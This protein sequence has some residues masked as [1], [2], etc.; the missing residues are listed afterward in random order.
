MQ[1]PQRGELQVLQNVVIDVDKAGIITAVGHRDG[2][3]T[4]NLGEQVVLLPGLIDTHMHAPQW[5]QLGTGLDLPLEQWL[6]EHT[7]PLEK[8]LTE[9]EF[10]A[11]VWP[12]MVQGLLS[13]GTTTAVYYATISVETTTML[14]ATCA[15]FGQRAFVGR[16]AMDYPGGTP[17]WYRD[18]DASAAIADSHASIEA[19]VGLGDGAVQPIITP[20]FAPACSN[21]ALIGLGQLS[22]ETGVRLQTHCSESDWQHEYAFERFRTSDTNA[23]A[24]F[25]LI[26]PNTVLAHGNHLADSDL[27]VIRLAGAGVAHCPLSNA[28]FGNSVFPARQALDSGVKVGLGTDIAGGASPGLLP[29]CAHAVTA[30]RYLEDG[31]NAALPAGDRGVADSRISIRDAFYMATVGGADL[32]N[33]PAGL[34]AVGRSFDALAVQINRQGSPLQ[35]WSELDRGDQI[36]E[37]VIRL[38]SPA[39]IEDVW[40]R[41]RRVAGSRDQA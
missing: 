29:Q 10:A 21:D 22:M 8:R 12:Q 32:L 33:I 13:H 37:K 18:A 7:F 20:R 35:V 36:F 4:H 41:G 27:D 34:L 30:S 16:V 23:L 5:P 17:E 19:I 38:A 11:K 15:E 39:D 26:R 24:G 25:G 9:P 6:I 3:V 14:A 1:T 28:Y 2:P 40:V 31:V